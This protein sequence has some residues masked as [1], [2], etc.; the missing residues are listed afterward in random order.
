MS[1]VLVQSIV[2]SWSN[3]SAL[4]KNTL[5]QLLTSPY[6]TVV[7]IWFGQMSCLFAD[8]HHHLP[9]HL[10]LNGRSIKLWRP[11]TIYWKFITQIQS[12]KGYLFKLHNIFVQ[13]AKCICSNCKM[14][15]SRLNNYLYKL[16]HLRLT[17][18]WRPDT[19]YWKFIT[20]IQSEKKICSNCKIYFIK[21]QNLFV[22][23]EQVFVQVRPLET[24]KTVGSWHHLLKVYYKNPNNKNYLSNWQNIYVQIAKCICL[25]WKRYLTFETE[26]S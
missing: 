5:K 11:T 10:R 15:L 21:L 22:Q 2:F 4:I 20:H 13:I 25:G 16:D 12:E 24:N 19:I 8:P 7:F 6:L 3:Y 18:L 14:Y 17:K 26:W 1:C 23:I 9:F